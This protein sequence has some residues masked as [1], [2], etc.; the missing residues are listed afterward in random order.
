MVVKDVGQ[1]IYLLAAAAVLFPLAASGQTGSVHGVVVD[2]ETGETLIGANVIVQGTITGATTDLEGRYEIR[3]LDPGTYE[4]TTSYLGYAEL[5]VTGV[6]VAPGQPV[7]LDFQLT[8]EAVGLDEVVVE[9]RAARNAEAALLRERQK[10]G[11]VSDA[12]SAEAIA[13]TGSSTASDAMQ[14]VAG[15]SV[16]GGKYVYVR[17]LGD[18]YTNT[19]LN[20]TTLPSADPDRNAVPLDLFP[21]ALLDNIVT[22]KTFTPDKPGSFTGGS[23]DI[24]TRAFPEQLAMSFSSSVGVDGQ[25]VSSA[26]IL[27]HETGSSGSAWLHPGTAP[28]VPGV[29][30]PNHVQARRNPEMAR[31][32]D[33]LARAFRPEMVPRVTNASLESSYGV[34]V[35]NQVALFGRPVGFLGSLTYD[36][37]FSAYSGGTSA[38]YLL[39]GNVAEVNELN[40]QQKLSDERST[41][42]VLWGGLGTVSIKPHPNH[43]VG[44]T[45][46]YNRSMSDDA[47]Y[48][49]GTVPRNFAPERRLESRVLART[50]RTLQSIQLKG[51]HAFQTRHALRSDWSI[52]RTRTEQEEPDLRYFANDFTVSDRNGTVDTLYSVAV[53][54]YTAPTRYFRNLAEDG[55]VSRPC[56]VAMA[57]GVRELLGADWGLATTGVAGPGPSDGQNAGTVHVAVAGEWL[58]RDSEPVTTAV[59]HGVGL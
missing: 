19:Q 49:T 4:L 30:S 8:P 26:Q 55:A 1:Y 28:G 37:D 53:S 40:V 56:A 16:V 54:N 50:E 23:V 31:T 47:R 59:P 18:R 42:E 33:Q 14:R 5:V 57:Q 48:L 46:M 58:L 21:A 36:R 45:L 27:A 34:S 7:Q 22:T 13:R 3:S 24:G 35:G 10:A 20:G 12:I 44:A 17:G 39:T 52:A 38:T 41:S 25:S 6:E 29:Q 9:A 15:A 51:E 11:A 43:S 2:A 32:L